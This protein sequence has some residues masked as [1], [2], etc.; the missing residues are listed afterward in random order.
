MT[1][2]TKNPHTILVVEDDSHDIVI[3]Q[4]QIKSLWPDCNIVP[5]KSMHAAYDAFKTQNFDMVLLD[6]NLPDTI[7]PNTVAEMRKFNRST[8]IIVLTGMLTSVTADESLKQGATN[9][10][11]KSQIEDEDFLNILE[12]NAAT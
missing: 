8:P 9:I 7:G 3:I 6:L 1:Q 11:P 2:N 5:V 10:F 4:R 12:Q